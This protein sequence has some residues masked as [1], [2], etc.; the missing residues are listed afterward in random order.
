MTTSGALSDLAGRRLSLKGEHLQ[1]TGSYKF[2]GAYNRISRLSPDT[3]GGVV[4]ASAGNHAQGVALAARLA[5]IRSTIFMPRTAPLPKVAA[6]RGYGAEVH[7]VGQLVD[8]CILAALEH[9]AATGGIFVPPFDDP[10][11]IAGQGTVGLELAEESADAEVV[12]VPVG[13]GGLIAGVATALALTRPAIR[14]VG[15]EAAGA[16]AVRASLD[17]G[18]CVVLDRVA[19]M[20]D[21]IALR[22]PSEL[23]LSHVQ[24]YVDDV[25]TV[26]EEEISSAVLLLLERTKALVEPAGAV[27]LAALLAGKVAGTGPATTILSGGNVDPLLLLKLVDHGLSAAGRYLVVRVVLGDRPGA[28][29]ALTAVL[30]ALGLN[31]LSVE[32]HRA[33]LAL[34]VDEV[35]VLLTLETRDPDHRHEVV[36]AIGDAGFT[37]DLVR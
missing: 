31:V 19:T 2:R 11:V 6:T 13:G 36:A 27:G 23:T 24:A 1:R 37:V 20:A 18:T 30:A 25:V 34:G 17:A 32:H 16:A 8:D 9:A 22:S 10:H 12:V 26:T 14:V 4:A 7:L 3:P 15:V 21:G 5:G 29:A 33:G 35:E 28:L